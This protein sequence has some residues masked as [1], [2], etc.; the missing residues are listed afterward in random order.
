MPSIIS[1]AIPNCERRQAYRDHSIESPK[2]HISVMRTGT[3]HI[4]I[5]G[6]LAPPQ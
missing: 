3:L 1:T 5:T 2:Q 4:T 6:S